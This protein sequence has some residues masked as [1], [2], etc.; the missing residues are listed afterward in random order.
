M[1]CVVVD[2]VDCARGV[3]GAS[4]VLSGI[5]I[6]IESGEVAAAD[7]EANAVAFAEDVTGGPDVDREFID[8]AGVQKRG[9]LLRI[10]ITRAKDAFRKILREAIRGD[11]YEFGSEVRVHGGRGSKE[12]ESHRASDFEILRE[13]GRGIDEN[14]VTGLN[15]ALVARSGMEML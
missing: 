4:V 5:H 15:R 9:L 14:I 2:G 8:L 13:R 7:F 11:I 1:F 10:A 6:A 3:A 12:F